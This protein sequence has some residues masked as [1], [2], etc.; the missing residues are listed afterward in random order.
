MF[1]GL[2]D[3]VYLIHRGDGIDT[4]RDGTDVP[5]GGFDT[6]RFGAGV[7]P[8]HVALYRT[9]DDLRLVLDNGPQQIVISSFFNASSD[10]RIEQFI[11]DNGNGPVWTLDDINAWVINGTP[12]AMLG[13][14]GDDRFSVDHAGDTVSEAPAAGTDTIESWVSYALPSNVENLILTGPLHIDGTGNALDN[15]LRGNSGNNVLAGA[16]GYDT[17]YGGAGDDIYKNIVA[18]VE[19]PDEGIDTWINRDGGVLPANV[20]NLSMDDDSGFHYIY[21]VSAIGNALDNTLTSGGVGVGGDILDGREGADTMIASGSDSPIFVVDN[22]GDK[23]IASSLGGS[24]DK[25]ISSIS[26]QLGP[27]V[28]NLTLTGTAPI[29]GTGN[30]L[31]NTLDGSPNSAANVLAGGKGN[32]T[33]IIGPGDIV[34]EAAGEGNDTLQI[35]TSPTDDGRTY[36]IEELNTANIEVFG[37]TGKGRNVTLVGNDLAN[38]LKGNEKYRSILVGGAGADTLLGGTGDDLLDGGAGADTMYGGG[39][40]DT[41]MVD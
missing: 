33:Y 14:S 1:G 8:E 30:D 29:S 19:A 7:L 32:D 17:A 41:Y 27:Y 38:T 35:A 31:N 11:F 16:G 22:V 26:Y 4:V 21:N 36:R 9:A 5:A 23:V 10:R 12:N 39:G 34:V 2:G 3:D 25:V 37:L 6:L 24:S 40:S 13:T 20:E 15:V 28:E 18:V